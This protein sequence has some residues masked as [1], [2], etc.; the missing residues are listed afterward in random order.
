MGKDG[1]W[2]TLDWCGFLGAGRATRTCK[3]SSRMVSEIMIDRGSPELFPVLRG[4]GPGPR[5]SQR[6]TQ[7]HVEPYWS[8]RCPVNLGPEKGPVLTHHVT[9]PD[10]DCD[11]KTRPLLVALWA[12]PGPQKTYI[13]DAV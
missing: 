1:A 6:A 3:F 7:A 4:P 5:L 2:F 10:S 13:H 9:A 11:L 8:N 12:G